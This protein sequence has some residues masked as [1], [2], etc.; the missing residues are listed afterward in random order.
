ML[1]AKLSELISNSKQNQK[2][3]KVILITN[4]TFL[5]EEKIKELEFTGL[6]QINISLN[7]ISNKKGKFLSNKKSYDTKKIINSILYLKQH[8]KIKVIIAP[9]YLH[10]FNNDEI[11]EI[12]RFGAKNKINVAIQNF[13][14]YKTGKRP[15]KAIP[16]E[17]FYEILKEW[18]MK[19]NVNLTKFDFEIKKDKVLE[20]PFRKNQVITAKIKSFGR[21][22]NEMLGVTPGISRVI[23]ILGSHKK[24][25]EKQKV[26]II[27]V[28]HNIIVGEAV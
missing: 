11:E 14:E 13:L 23:S 28:K 16:F 26:K 17:Q 3:E 21:F 22:S 24:I 8:T 1:Y 15:I 27:R 2:I 10:N 6:D 19:Y 9:V 5:D 7:S 4:G 20:L 18:E 25:G 12:I